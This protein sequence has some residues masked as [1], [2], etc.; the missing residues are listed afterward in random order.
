MKALI[1]FIFI[2]F[3]SLTSCTKSSVCWEC[4]FGYTAGAQQRPPETVCQDNEP[5]QQWFDANGNMLNSQC[6]RK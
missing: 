1:T 5:T 4:T 2:V 3:I 6:V